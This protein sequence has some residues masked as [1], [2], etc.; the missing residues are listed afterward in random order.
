VF[1][2]LYLLNIN[3]LTVKGFNLKDL[4]TKAAALAGDNL[5]SQEQVNALQS[6]YALSARADKLNMV[7]VG[8]IDYLT[9]NRSA[10]AM[11][12]TGGRTLRRTDFNFFGFY[13]AQPPKK[14][15]ARRRPDKL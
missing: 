2:L 14:F 3:D 13:V 1:G 4:Q 10:V 7:A 6:Y 5:A 8:N 15:P 9:V 11:K 12:I